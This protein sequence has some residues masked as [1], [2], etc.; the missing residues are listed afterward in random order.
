MKHSLLIRSCLAFA[1]VCS[2][3]TAQVLPPVVSGSLNLLAKP[4]DVSLTRTITQSFS[5]GA[6]TLTAAPTTP[7][8]CLS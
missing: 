6:A 2:L 5:P 3:G 4:S 1:A 8:T 7:A